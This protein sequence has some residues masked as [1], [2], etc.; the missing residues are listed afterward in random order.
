MVVVHCVSLATTETRPGLYLPAAHQGP[1]DRGSGVR[2]YTVHSD[3][4]SVNRNL[5]IETQKT[6]TE[7]LQQNNYLVL[8]N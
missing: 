7:E 3:N 2:A 6:Q 4:V 8:T 5:T 1:A